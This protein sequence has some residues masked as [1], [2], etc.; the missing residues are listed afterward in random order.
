[1]PNKELFTPRWPLERLRT[2]AIFKA[3]SGSHV[4][5]ASSAPHPVGKEKQRQRH[6]EICSKWMELEEIILIEEI[7]TQQDKRSI[8]QEA[9][10]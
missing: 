9:A 2:S 10:S 6:L 5:E 1:M 4:E 7:Q 8:L 3:R